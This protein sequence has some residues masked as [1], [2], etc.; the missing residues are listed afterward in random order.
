ME[1]ELCRSISFLAY[2]DYD[3]IRIPPPRIP[4]QDQVRT[5]DLQLRPEPTPGASAAGAA[6]VHLSTSSLEEAIQ[7]ALVQHGEAQEI[8]ATYEQIVKRL[9]GERVGFDQQIS[10]LERTFSVKRHDLQ[11]LELLSTETSRAR[12]AA[13]QELGKQKAACE[14]ELAQREAALQEKQQL[15][16]QRLRRRKE[17]RRAAT[18]T[19]RPSS[20]ADGA[21][22]EV[23]VINK[24]NVNPVDRLTTQSVLIHDAFIRCRRATRAAPR[25]TT[26]HRWSGATG[27][28][29]QRR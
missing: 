9:K 13:Q 22:D 2:N 21:S 12:D 16:H 3:I 15:I 18:R 6:G 7:R 14:Q 28:T 27:T 17:A 11:E 20:D 26:R 23:G 10:A 5:L 25:A 29:T 1:E 8:R 4:T 24:K 19:T